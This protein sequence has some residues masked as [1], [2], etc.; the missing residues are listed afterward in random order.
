MFEADAVDSVV[1]LDV[2]AKVVAVELE[3]VAGAQ[4]GVLVEFG[5]Q[6][7][8]RPV[9]FELPVLVARRLGLVVDRLA[10]DGLL[11]KSETGSLLPRP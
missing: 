1:K 7:R 3:L 2:D 10:Q 4:T 6:S 8:H 11:E 5:E 9:Y